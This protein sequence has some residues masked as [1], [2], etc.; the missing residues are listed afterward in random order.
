MTIER[1]C[2]VSGRV[3]GKAAKLAKM[4][5]ARHSIFYIDHRVGNTSTIRVLKVDRPHL[6]YALSTVGA[7]NT[8]R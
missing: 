2:T 7:E 4:V 1:A 3:S 5:L 8:I 6:E